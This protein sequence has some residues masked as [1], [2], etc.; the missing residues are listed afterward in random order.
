MLIW[1]MRS[2]GRIISSFS[3]ASV[4]SNRIQEILDEKSEF[5]IDLINEEGDWM[6][7]WMHINTS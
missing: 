1:P 6:D 2:L 7:L 5:E 3:K 4:A